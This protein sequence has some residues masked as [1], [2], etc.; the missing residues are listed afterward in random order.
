MVFAYR[1]QIFATEA[2]A[3]DYAEGL[4][5]ELLKREGLARGFALSEVVRFCEIVLKNR[6]DLT[7]LLQYEL[8]DE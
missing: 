3:I 1:G 7:D 5:F 4:A 6:Q 8:D 2:Q